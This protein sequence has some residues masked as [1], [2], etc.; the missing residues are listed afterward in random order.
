[1]ACLPEKDYNAAYTKLHTLFMKYASRTFK[2]AKSKDDVLVQLRP[3]TDAFNILLILA[4]KKVAHM[5][6]PYED[7]SVDQLG[8]EEIDEVT[9]KLV[10]DIIELIYEDFHLDNV[11]IKLS[12]EGYIWITKKNFLAQV[13]ETKSPH[14]FDFPMSVCNSNSPDLV[15]V[16]FGLYESKISSAIPDRLI[17]FLMEYSASKVAALMGSLAVYRHVAV[18]ANIGLTVTMSISF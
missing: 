9:E 1:M 6:Y 3:E 2:Y 15:S 11:G 17:T 13:L 10:E 18:T 5:F 12:S 8:D 14:I 7:Q 16:R 4:G